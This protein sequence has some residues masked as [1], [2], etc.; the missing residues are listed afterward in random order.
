MSFIAENDSWNYGDII[1]NN[2]TLTQ[3]NRT[4]YPINALNNNITITL[5]PTPDP[6][7]PVE[8][9]LLC[10]TRNDY[11]MTN[12]VTIVANI[13]GFPTNIPIYPNSNAIHKF[14]TVYDPQGLT[15]YSTIYDV[16][17]QDIGSASDRVQRDSVDT[18]AFTNLDIN[19]NNYIGLVVSGWTLA[20]DNSLL[21]TNQNNTYQNGVYKVTP[22]GYIVHRETEPLGSDG[23]YHT[24]PVMRGDAAGAVFRITNT[25]NVE[26][27]AIYGESRLSISVYTYSVPN[28]AA[29]VTKAV[30]V[31]ASNSN[32][33][34]TLTNYIGR[35]IGGYV[36]SV[37]DRLALIGN[38]TPV[39]NGVYVVQAGGGIQRSSDCAAG[40]DGNGFVFG[41]LFGTFANYFYRISL[42]GA[43]TTAIFG[44]DIANYDVY[45]VIQNL[46]ADGTSITLTGNT[47]AVATSG[48]GTTQLAPYATGNRIMGTNSGTKKPE[49]TSIPSD[50]LASVMG[51]TQGYVQVASFG[52][53]TLGTGYMVPYATLGAALSN[54]TGASVIQMIGGYGATGAFTQSQDNVHIEGFGCDGSQSANITGSI[55]AP[56]GR[57][58]LKLKDLALIGNAANPIPY[59]CNSGNLGR[60]YFKNVSFTPYTTSPSV[61]ITSSITNWH[62]FDD[63]DFATAVNIGGSVGSSEA[64]TFRNCRGA[65]YL[66]LTKNVPVT[67][68]DCDAVF[69]MSHT[70]GQILVYGRTTVNIASTAT[71]VSGALIY[72]EGCTTWNV[73]TQ[74]WGAINSLCTTQLNNVSRQ[75]S[76]DSIAAL[77]TLKTPVV[78]STAAANYY[79]SGIAADGTLQTSLLPSA[80][81]KDTGVDTAVTINNSNSPYPLAANQTAV[82]ADA[83]TGSVIITLPPISA[84]STSLLNKRYTI[85][86]T[87]VM[88]GNS[89]IIQC[90][91]GTTDSFQRSPV[92]FTQYFL[93]T[94]GSIQLTAVTKGGGNVWVIE[95]T[96]QSL[97]QT[98]PFGN[99]ITSDLILTYHGSLFTVNANSNINITLPLATYGIGSTKIIRTDKNSQ[100]NVNLVAPASHTVNGVAS[101]PL[102][103]DGA[104]TCRTISYGNSALVA[105]LAQPSSSTF[106]GAICQLRSVPNQSVS[107]TA[108][109]IL[110]RP[111]DT[112][113]T[114]YDPLGL[115]SG[116]I[117]SSRITIQTAGVYEVTAGF[118]AQVT[119]NN[120]IGCGIFKNGSVYTENYTSS[121]GAVGAGNGFVQTLI[122]CNVGD[123]L[124]VWGVTGSGT[125]AYMSAFF[126]V[127][128]GQGIPS[129]LP[130][131]G[132]SGQVLTVNGSG[133]GLQYSTIANTSV[134]GS[135]LALRASTGQNIGNS[136][137]TSVIFNTADTE[138]EMRPSNVGVTVTENKTFTNNTGSAMTITVSLQV[139]WPFNS[140]GPRYVWIQRIST[141]NR[142]GMVATAPVNGGA[143]Q[144]TSATFSLASGDGF[145]IN[146]YQNSGSTL[147]LNDGDVGLGVGYAGRIQITRI[148]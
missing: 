65:I 86:R 35:N 23:K 112:G 98:I 115:H 83:S 48:V 125:Y 148:I 119:G 81:T 15:P 19:A 90:N 40:V 105:E 120:Y 52:S 30:V 141:S 104:A 66:Y 59:L 49:E 64:Y 132:S 25:Q 92:G 34:I 129:N 73:Q 61:N 87:D 24:F 18:A 108:S 74:S 147:T 44:T 103:V 43:N 33:D 46:V 126:N 106:N 117:N 139:Q 85:H 13:G 50:K 122:S 8:S 16:Q 75:A 9:G 109:V 124:E 127:K 70:A 20:A 41:I 76:N 39:E 38:N 136:A 17:V 22:L 62:E 107:P 113:Y 27:P 36:V 96:S 14:R 78:P 146:V 1:S 134:T 118:Y 95:N 31:T 21:L 128:L 68:V 144:S 57:T 135:V 84:V 79:V 110:F 130:S 142:V 60:N 56:S 116:T 11:N 58:M 4:Y 29:R 69:V 111:S 114:T 45:F 5:P 53:D 63:C 140:G 3:W 93:G 131:L 143:V 6:S 133:S 82:N 7:N 123:Y 102:Y 47:L 80:A 55:T 51:T 89:V 91:S 137:I 42:N 101:V 77:T 72:L 145:I 67:F 94:A 71:L 32:E 121:G 37:G 26:A 12:T 138:L 99:V 88:N 100:Y 2:I 28:E 97:Y 10:F 54:L